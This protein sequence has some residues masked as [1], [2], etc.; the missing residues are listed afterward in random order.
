MSLDD[1]QKILNMKNEEL[2]KVHNESMK[3]YD[4]E[5]LLEDEIRQLRLN[6]VIES[7]I[8]ST[9]RWNFM[10]FTEKDVLFNIDGYWDEL[11]DIIKP[12][13][14]EHQ[15]ILV[16][17]ELELY[18]GESVLSEGYNIT[19]H[20]NKNNVKEWIEKLNLTITNN[21]ID[22]YVDENNKI[23]DK[24]RNDLKILKIIIGDYHE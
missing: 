2:K 17:S 10:R 11:V 3:I 9:K 13:C 14:D 16:K 19:L 6:I 24:L 12:Y 7:N 1:I 18:M 8:L 20:I 22:K 21:S 15:F 5:Q 4:E 23:I